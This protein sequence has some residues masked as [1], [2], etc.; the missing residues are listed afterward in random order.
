MKRIDLGLGDCDYID[1]M[2]ISRA[3][4][5]QLNVVDQEAIFLTR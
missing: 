3:H 5:L 2:G 1:R 4:M